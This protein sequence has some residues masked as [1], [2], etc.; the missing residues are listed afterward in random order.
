GGMIF[1]FILIMYWR[2]KDRG[3]GYYYN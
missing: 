3:N 2:K 1:G